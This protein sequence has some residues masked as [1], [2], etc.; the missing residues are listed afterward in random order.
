MHLFSVFKHRACQSSYF[1]PYKLYISEI[2]NQYS[3]YTEH[4]KSSY[5]QSLKIR[6]ECLL[7]EQPV[8][9]NGLNLWASALII[10]L[11]PVFHLASSHNSRLILH[12]VVIVIP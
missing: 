12:I 10:G 9:Y 5:F 2:G 11:F 1:Q 6:L 7:I 8:A 3:I 4:I